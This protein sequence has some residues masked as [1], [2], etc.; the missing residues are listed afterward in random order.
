MLQAHGPSLR[1][2]SNPPYQYGRRIHSTVS[3]S[4]GSPV[5]YPVST[6]PSML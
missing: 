1:L 4:T 6:A 3:N 5:A 2:V